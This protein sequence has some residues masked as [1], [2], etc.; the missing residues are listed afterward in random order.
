MAVSLPFFL[1]PSLCLTSPSFSLFYSSSKALSSAPSVLLCGDSA[2]IKVKQ[3]GEERVQHAIQQTLQQSVCVFQS[4]THQNGGLKLPLFFFMA[5][6][7]FIIIISYMVQ[8]CSEQSYKLI[9]KKNNN[10]GNAI[11]AIKKKEEKNAT[12]E[13]VWCSSLLIV[14]VMIHKYGSAGSFFT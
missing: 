11:Q 12:E 2:L 7:S 9:R 3:K 10:H 4:D 13:T 1:S 5:S 8:S 14:T 6:A